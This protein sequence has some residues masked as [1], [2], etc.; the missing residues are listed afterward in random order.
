MENNKTCGECKHFYTSDEGQCSLKGDW[1]FSD[2][3][4]CKDF[5]LPI[6]RLPAGVITAPKPTNGDKIIAGGSKALVKFHLLGTCDTCIYYN[7][8]HTSHNDICL[9]PKDKTCADG[10][11]AWLN[12]TAESE[13]ENA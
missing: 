12:A 1:G 7:K 2:D 8:E 6:D 13:A 4:A 9:C 11:E 3:D 5:C 10:I